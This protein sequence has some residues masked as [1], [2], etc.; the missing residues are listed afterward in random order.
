V[1]GDRE[2]VSTTALLDALVHL[3]DSPWSDLRGKPLD[4]RR[5]SALLKQYEVKRTTFREGSVT[6]MG[7]RRE[8]L[9]DA[10]G[11]YVGVGVAANGSEN[12]GNTSNTPSEW[13]LLEVRW[14][15]LHLVPPTDG[16]AAVTM[17]LPAQ[18]RTTHEGAVLNA[19]AIC[20]TPPHTVK[21]DMYRI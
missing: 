9:H 1:F 11:R 4:A 5:L 19:S 3:E 20:A 2:A 17:M 13:R 8:D 7:Y 10:W 18:V 15:G 14:R 16:G 6:V 12:N 21:L